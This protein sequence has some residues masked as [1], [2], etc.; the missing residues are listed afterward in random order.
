MPN[1]D[2]SELD[3]TSLPHDDEEGHI[4]SK[5][6]GLSSVDNINE[7]SNTNA[8]F[9]DTYDDSPMDEENDEYNDD[10]EDDEYYDENKYS[11]QIDKDQ[12]EN[13]QKE[14]SNIPNPPLYFFRYI[15]LIHLALKQ[16]TKVKQYTCSQLCKPA[17]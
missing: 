1:I 2:V 5:E 14:A 7:K 4:D 9:Y 15:H 3:P 13:K 10:K 11:Y 16:T 17:L 8:Y 6:E 12:Q